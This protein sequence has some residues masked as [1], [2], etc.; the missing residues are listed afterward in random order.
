MKKFKYIFST[1]MIAI[2]MVISLTVSIGL[3]NGINMWKCI[4]AYWIVLFTKNYVD[5]ILSLIMKE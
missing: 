1:F 5:Y 2:L 4:V 3:M